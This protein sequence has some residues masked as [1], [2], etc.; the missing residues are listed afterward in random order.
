MLTLIASFVGIAV[1]I[2]RDTS[3]TGGGGG[4]G[5]VPTKAIL[6]RNTNPIFQRNGALILL[7]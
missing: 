1:N 7:R 3:G 2:W 4:G 6:Q 5:G